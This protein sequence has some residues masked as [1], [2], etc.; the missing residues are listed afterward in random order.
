MLHLIF[1]FLRWVSMNILCQILFQVNGCSLYKLLEYYWYRYGEV[2][3][4][5]FCWR[6]RIVVYV[7]RIWS[8]ILTTIVNININML[9]RWVD[10][11]L[12][13]A[14]YIIYGVTLITDPCGSPLSLLLYG[15]IEY[16]QL[17]LE[18]FGQIVNCV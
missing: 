11:V 16:F 9:C 7:E 8:Q 4:F 14:K 5:S 15:Q 1:S 10:S 2:C 17:K 3:Y 12:Y 13:V 6:L 18:L